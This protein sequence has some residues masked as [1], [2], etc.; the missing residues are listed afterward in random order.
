MASVTSVAKYPGY[1]HI[2]QFNKLVK[3]CQQATA[4]SPMPGIAVEGSY[5][6][7]GIWPQRAQSS[8]RNAGDLTHA[9]KQSVVTRGAM[10]LLE[11]LTL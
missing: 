1:V 9:R 3:W 11:V 8:Q 6:E 4:D 10:V 2:S 7:K 5:T